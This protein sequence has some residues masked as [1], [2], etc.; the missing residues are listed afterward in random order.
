LNL[1]GRCGARHHD[2][3]LGAKPLS[4]ESHALSVIA[5]GGADHAPLKGFAWQAYHL[6]VGAA[7]LEREDRLEIFPIKSNR[8][9]QTL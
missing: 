9:S 1:D 2:G 8:A 6:G 7:Q 5:G 3:C 4:G